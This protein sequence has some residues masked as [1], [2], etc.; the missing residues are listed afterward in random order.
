MSRTTKVEKARKD[1]N[2]YTGHNT[3]LTSLNSPKKF[4][5]KGLSSKFPLNKIKLA[6]KVWPE[7]PERPQRPNRLE[8]PQRPKRLQGRK[9]RKGHK[10]RKAKAIKLCFLKVYILRFVIFLKIYRVF[11]DHLTLNETKIVVITLIFPEAKTHSRAR[12]LGLVGLLGL[13]FQI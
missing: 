10:A 1:S 2:I 4:D 5:Q 11:N 8:R 12:A 3:Y 13:F 7:G 9:G 6:Q